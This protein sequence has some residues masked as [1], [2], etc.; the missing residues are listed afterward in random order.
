MIIDT[1]EINNFRNIQSATLKVSPG[2]NL[3]CG[4]NGAGKTSLLEAIY[5]AFMGRSFRTN[6]SSLLLNHNFDQAVVRITGEKYDHAMED[7]ANTEVGFVKDKKAP[8]IKIRSD[9]QWISSLQQHVLEHPVILLSPYNN[10]LIE[11]QPKLRRKFIDFVLFYTDPLFTA[12]WKQYTKIMRQRNAL[13]RAKAKYTDILPW[14]NQL[15]SLV[16]DITSSRKRIS[17]ALSTRLNAIVTDSESSSFSKFRNVK[18]SCAGY[19]DTETLWSERAKQNYETDLKY[20]YTSQGPHKFDVHL[21]DGSN[22]IKNI[23]SRGEQK[24]L[25]TMLILCAAYYLLDIKNTTPIVFLYDDLSAELDQ[26]TIEVLIKHMQ[27]LDQQVFITS[28]HD[29]MIDDSQMFHVEHGKFS[30]QDNVPRG[31]SECLG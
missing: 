2:L 3:V 19:T 16:K 14:D 18:I 4:K 6:R 27:A 23:Y 12:S 20:G 15:D 25:T 8:G 11:G 21:K 28:T 17:E 22:H 13:I 24:L 7:I 26:S 30:T 10:Q 5:A 9:K 29:L 31:T 1:I